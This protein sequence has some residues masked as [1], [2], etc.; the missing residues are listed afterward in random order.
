MR[1]DQTAAM[2]ID[3][4]SYSHRW[5]SPRVRRAQGWRAVLPRRAAMRRGASVARS[6][7]PVVRAFVGAF[8]HAV[9]PSRRS[10]R[11]P[12]ASGYLLMQEEGRPSGSNRR[13]LDPAPGC[14]YL[15]RLSAGAIGPGEGIVTV[16]VTARN[17]MGSPVIE[18]KAALRPL[19]AVLSVAVAVAHR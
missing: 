16:E 7:R 17:Q 4:I 10:W 11:A 18:T 14:T 2:A 3:S 5:R 12:V 6:S 19:S 13:F 9:A 8:S 15:V 1:R